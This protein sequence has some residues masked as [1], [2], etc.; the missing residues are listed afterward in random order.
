MGTYRQ[1]KWM[2]PAVKQYLY[3]ARWRAHRDRRK[4][5]S[6]L[7]F[8]T[9]LPRLRRGVARDLKVNDDGKRVGWCN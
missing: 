7:A 6:M 2:P 4:F 8:G 1:P 3:H 5:D 9:A